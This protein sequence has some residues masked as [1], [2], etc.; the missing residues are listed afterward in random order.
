MRELIQQA[1]SPPDIEM[2]TVIGKLMCLHLDEH[3]IAIYYQPTVRILECFYD[4]ELEDFIIG[5]LKDLIQVTGE[6]KVCTWL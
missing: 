4:I 2:M 3:K 5:N 1:V 6:G